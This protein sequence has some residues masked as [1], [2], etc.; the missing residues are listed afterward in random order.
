V[1]PSIRR[2]TVFSVPEV[3]DHWGKDY[4]LLTRAR[5]FGVTSLD[6]LRPRSPEAIQKIWQ[7]LENRLQPL[8]H[9]LEGRSKG[10]DGLPWDFDD[11]DNESLSKS[12]S[13]VSKRVRYLCGGSSPTYGDFIIMAMLA[14]IARVDLQV[15]MRLTHDVGG[16][17]LRHLWEGCSPYLQ[18]GDDI[19]TLDWFTQ[20]A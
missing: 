1:V 8:V 20:A 17:V 5:E 15:W 19:A 2:L 11:M 12:K 4:F 13:E 9:A 18:S 6:E 16:G 10:D 7:D 14:W 3:L